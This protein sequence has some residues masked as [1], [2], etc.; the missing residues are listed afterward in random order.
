M[1]S[2]VSLSISSS[3]AQLIVDT[4]C[5]VG[6][7]DGVTMVESSPVMSARNESF[8]ANDADAAAA[9]V[10]E[11]PEVVL[12]LKAAAALRASEL[13]AIITMVVSMSTLDCFL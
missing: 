3:V 10:A 7:A 4:S 12:L 11:S 8:N 9:D 5:L 13:G 2:M 6:V 1:C